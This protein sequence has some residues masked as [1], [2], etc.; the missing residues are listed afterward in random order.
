MV[1]HNWNVIIIHWHSFIINNNK[2]P[3]EAGRYFKVKL[4]RGIGGE[5]PPSPK[6]EKESHVNSTRV[7]LART[8]LAGVLVTKFGRLASSGV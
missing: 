5:M 1:H 4:V 6:L 3:Q 2:E 7:P 8:P